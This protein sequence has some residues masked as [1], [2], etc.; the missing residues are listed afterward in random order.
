MAAS[1]RISMRNRNSLLFV[2]LCNDIR[3]AAMHAFEQELRHIHIAT[4]I[5]TYIAYIA[6]HVHIAIYIYYT[7]YDTNIN[8]KKC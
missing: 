7:A 3:H 4:H 2:N 5:Y 6:I 8:S 1:Y